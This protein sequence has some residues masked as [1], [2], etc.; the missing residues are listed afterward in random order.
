MAF[1]KSEI[2]KLGF[3]FALILL[4]APQILKFGNCFRTQRFVLGEM[5]NWSQTAAPRFVW[6]LCQANLRAPPSS[7]PL[8]LFPSHTPTAQP[9]TCPE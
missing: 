1:F 8:S 2:D 4:H 3:F 9:E 7:V 5:K 6:S